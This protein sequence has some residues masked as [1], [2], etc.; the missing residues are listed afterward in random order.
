M[1]SSAHLTASLSST[2]QKFFLSLQAVAHV[3]Q[4][5]ELVACILSHI[6]DIQ[7][8]IRCAAINK[9]W[10]V[11]SAKVQPKSLL[12]PHTITYINELGPQSI[13]Q[14]MR[15]KYQQ[16]SFCHL[17]SIALEVCGDDRY[18]ETLTAFRLAVLTL[19][20]LCLLKICHIHYDG[21]PQH[22]LMLMPSTIQHLKL[23][24]DTKA[25]SPKDFDLSGFHR[26]RW[27]KS[28]HLQCSLDTG[29]RA[30]SP[31]FVFKGNKGLESLEG[32]RLPWPLRY[33]SI[34]L[35]QLKPNLRFAHLIA[36]ESDVQSYAELPNLQGLVLRLYHDIDNDLVTPVLSV[37]PSSE[38]QCL[39]LTIPHGPIRLTAKLTKPGLVH[40]IACSVSNLIIADDSWDATADVAYSVAKDLGTTG[41]SLPHF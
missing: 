14:W 7:D 35:A 40:S 15:L 27:L 31:M 26:L 9:C 33:P 16:Q 39:M 32:L 19:T 24:F 20:S 37:G 8:M 28:L 38:L 36:H 6:D 13:L 23:S 25:Q 1:K 30:S 17:E 3:L 12:I 29:Y 21:D 4:N 18:T 11:A 22:L 41:G 10:Q 34:P 5:E 2:M